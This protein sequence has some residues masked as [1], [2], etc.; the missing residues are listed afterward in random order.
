MDDEDTLGAR[1]FT[2][3][4]FA[5]FAVIILWVIDLHP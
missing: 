2:Y 4:A 1:D 3:F 5:L